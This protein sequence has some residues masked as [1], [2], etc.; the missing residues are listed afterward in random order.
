LGKRQHGKLTVYIPVQ[1]KMVVV[2]VCEHAHVYVFAYVFMA[3][4]M[5]SSVAQTTQQGT[6]A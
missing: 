6:I 2:V 1:L 4:L 3:H 5:M